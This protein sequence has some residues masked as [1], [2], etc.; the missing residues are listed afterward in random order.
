MNPIE[1]FVRRFQASL[2]DNS[3]RKLTLGKFRGEHANLEHVYAR[4]ISIKEEPK[5]SFTYRYPTQDVTK[6]FTIGEGT[7]LVRDWIGQESLSAT[8]FSATERQQLL[9]NRRGKP[10]LIT[11][12]ESRP[13]PEPTHDRKKVRALRDERF[14]RA[15]GVL[16][17][18]GR[19]RPQMG[20]KHR[21]IHQFVEIIAPIL[22]DL[23]NEQPLRVVDMGAGKGY[24][25]FAL[26]AFLREQGIALETTGI[27]RRKEL[28]EFCNRVAQECGYSGLHFR[29]GQIA[30]MDVQGVDILVALHACD[31]GTDE[32]IFQGVRGDAQWILVAP[33]CHQ[34]V[35]PQIRAPEGIQ[36]LFQNGIQIDRM[37]E[38]VTDTLRSMY[39]QACGYVTRIQEFIAVEH[40][41][42]NLLI[43]AQKLP[44][45]VDR[46]VLW[47]RAADFQALFRI[48]HQRLA[49]LLLARS[50]GAPISVRQGS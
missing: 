19:P 33:C 41:M 32:A 11:A 48:K 16:D 28:V 3:F 43:I 1:T 4:L 27:E 15:L 40:T 50:R 36:P 30:D 12:I 35:R 7:K 29:T 31:T 10:R 39:L 18:R 23:P 5:L 46:E 17:A 45:D 47:K 38:A 25:T 49:E 21:Q 2:M 37:A 42:K 20:D 6:N 34:E 22:R 24:L 26:H 44:Q 14:L 8:L 13:E 9:F